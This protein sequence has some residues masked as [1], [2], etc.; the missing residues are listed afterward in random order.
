MLEHINSQKCYRMAS[1]GE[2]GKKSTAGKRGNTHSHR[3]PPLSNMVNLVPNTVN[4]CN[5]GKFP[6]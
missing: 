3:A 1:T 2:S 5:L 4:L 6:N